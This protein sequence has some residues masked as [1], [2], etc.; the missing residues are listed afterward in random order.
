MLWLGFLLLGFTHGGPPLPTGNLRGHHKGDPAAP[1][2]LEFV[3][4][5]LCPDSAQAAPTLDALLQHY[6]TQR[7]N[8][9]VHTFPLPYHRNAFLAHQ[10][11]RVI[12]ALSG[13]VA[14]WAFYDVMWTK[15]D[16][17][18]DLVT[19]NSTQRDMWEAYSVVAQAVGVSP[20]SFIPRMNYS[21]PTDYDARTEWK[22]SASR[23]VYGTPTFF[24]NGV[25]LDADPSWTVDDWKQVLDPLLW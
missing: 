25:E 21:D 16:Q 6:S 19:L 13:D 5:H 1:I 14:W 8:L 23:G 9:I 3:F 18:A 22:Y 17:F 24:V 12:D 11:N 15:Q 10:A 4:D 7:M 20:S 2:Q